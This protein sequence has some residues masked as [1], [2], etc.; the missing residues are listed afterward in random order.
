M[1]AIVLIIIVKKGSFIKNRRIAGFLRLP[2]SISFF[3]VSRE[4]RYDSESQCSVIISILRLRMFDDVQITFYKGDFFECA[5][6]I[7]KEIYCNIQ[8]VGIVLK[9]SILQ[10]V[11]V[12][13]LAY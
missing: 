2:F 7:S 13:V 9:L 1:R 12:I 4:R 3:D 11:F 5:M 10:S 8:V 6:H